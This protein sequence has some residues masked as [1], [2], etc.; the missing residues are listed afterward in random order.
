VPVRL[1]DCRH[2]AL[3]KLRH[4][5]RRVW[6]R[7]IEEQEVSVAE[8]IGRE[9]KAEVGLGRW[10]VTVP[11]RTI[12][13]DNRRPVNRVLLGWECWENEQFVAL[14]SRYGSDSAAIRCCDDSLPLGEIVWSV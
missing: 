12:R 11:T 13:Y 10:Q 4:T 6:Q 8:S 7:L 2:D 9:L 5:A 1:A 14:R 3:R